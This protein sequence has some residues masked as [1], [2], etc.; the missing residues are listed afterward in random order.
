[1]EEKNPLQDKEQDKIF[2]RETAGGFFALLKVPAPK[3]K[4]EAKA[5]L[6]TYDDG[7]EELKS[8]I[9]ESGKKYSLHTLV[10][11]GSVLGEAL[12]I[13]LDGAWVFSNKKNRWVMRCSCEK[14]IQKEVDIFDLVEKSILGEMKTTL[15]VHCMSLERKNEF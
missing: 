8:Y 15:Y 3:D 9:Q 1:M 6:A 11:F 13:L 5:F 4:K 12:R 14:G 7:V 10:L 2:F